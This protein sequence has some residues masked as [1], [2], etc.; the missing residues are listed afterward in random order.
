MDFL[1]TVSNGLTVLAFFAFLIISVFVKREGKDERSQMM[2]YK[3]M[4]FLFTFLFGGL[5]L[6][7]FVTGWFDID[8]TLLRVSISLLL[9]L[10][11]LMGSIYWFSLKRVM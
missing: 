3:L 4:S 5:A 10:T 11:V 7:I 1:I 9:S 6:I 8:Y 2:G